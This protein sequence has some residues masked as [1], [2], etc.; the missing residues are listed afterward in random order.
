[1]VNSVPSGGEI[2]FFSEVGELDEIITRKMREIYMSDVTYPYVDAASGAAEELNKARE[3]FNENIR[4]ESS[5]VDYSKDGLLFTWAG[6]KINHTI[7]LACKLLL[8]KPI[9]A[10]YIYLKGMTP[11]D[12]KA[13]LEKPKPHPEELAAL[14]EREIKVKQ[15]YD[16]FLSDELLNHE[17][18]NACLDVDKAWEELEKYK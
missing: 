17:Y 5:Y 11:E 2:R 15:K 14:V 9:E 18:A 6:A 8:D 12:V 13:I 16:R 10:D 7:A 1:M 4:G 3:Y